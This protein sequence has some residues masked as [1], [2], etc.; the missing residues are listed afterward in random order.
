VTPEPGF[1]DTVILKGEYL[2]SNAFYR[3]SDRIR[4]WLHVK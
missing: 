2:Q 1:K 3:H 4:P